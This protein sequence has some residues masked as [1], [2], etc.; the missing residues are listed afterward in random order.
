MSFEKK[1]EL[2]ESHFFNS[3][4]SYLPNYFNCVILLNE[5]NLM[6]PFRA[7]FQLIFRRI[8]FPF[9]SFKLWDSSAPPKSQK[10]DF[11]LQ[12]DCWIYQKMPTTVLSFWFA[13]L[14]YH[15]VLILYLS[16]ILHFI[17]VTNFD[18]F[19]QFDLLLLTF[20]PHILHNWLPPVFGFTLITHDTLF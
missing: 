9:C 17:F 3:R 6:I 2:K 12:H 4:V 15:F 5:T 18:L 1:S 10:T 8:P 20:H 16:N 13:H 19:L 7:A 14:S 11:C